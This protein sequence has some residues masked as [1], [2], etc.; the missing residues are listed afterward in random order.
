MVLKCHLASFWLAL[1]RVGGFHLV[2]GAH[3]FPPQN[4]CVLGYIL[5]NTL[6]KPCLE[7]INLKSQINPSIAFICH[8]PCSVPREGGKSQSKGNTWIEGIEHSSLKMS[9]T[10]FE[11]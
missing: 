2:P 1:G 9:T 8:P 3:G 5:P 7:Y 11:S 10:K 6:N 4:C